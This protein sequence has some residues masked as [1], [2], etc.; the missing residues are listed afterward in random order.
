MVQVSVRRNVL[1]TRK[2]EFTQI[3]AARYDNVALP[4][5]RT[6]SIKSHAGTN[7]SPRTEGCK[8]RAK[9]YVWIRN[10]YFYR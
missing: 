2:A 6:E 4:D 1:K 5:R 9:T 10:L 8:I 3:M 7:N